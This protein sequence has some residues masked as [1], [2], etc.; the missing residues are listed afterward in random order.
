MNDVLW[1]DH[2]FESSLAVLSKG[3]IFSFQHFGQF[4]ILLNFKF[5]D[6]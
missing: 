4:Q 3:T 1:S 6:F 5:A 2:L